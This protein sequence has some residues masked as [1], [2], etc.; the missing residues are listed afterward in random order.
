M[1]FNVTI[2][3]SCAN[4]S[5][6]DDAISLSSGSAGYADKSSFYVMPDDLH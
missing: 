4:V 6:D 5:D 1:I 3:Q 2:E